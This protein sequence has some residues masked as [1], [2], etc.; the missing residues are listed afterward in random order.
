MKALQ[1]AKHQKGS[2]CSFSSLSLSLAKALVLQYFSVNQ[3]LQV[4]IHKLSANSCIYLRF[5]SI[6]ESPA[7]VQFL[8][9]ELSCS[10]L[11]FFLMDAVDFQMSIERFLVWFYLFVKDEDCKWIPASGS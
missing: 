7:D 2:A 3:L 9:V 10:L 8:Y 11:N 5:R 6:L 4:Q 1:V